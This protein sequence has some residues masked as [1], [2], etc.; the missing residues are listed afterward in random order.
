MAA[1]M[2]A[3]SVATRLAEYGSSGVVGG[4]AAF[5]WLV[6]AK[7]PFPGIGAGGAG[8]G[9][10]GATPAGATGRFFFAQRCD[11]RRAARLLRSRSRSRRERALCACCVERRD[12]RMRRVL[13][14]LSVFL[15]CGL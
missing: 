2:D 8:T 10:A 1:A 13:D 11:R 3:D 9:A 5:H 12:S 7:K 6:G 14:F 15:H 4:S